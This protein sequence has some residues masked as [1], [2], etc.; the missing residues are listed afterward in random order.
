MQTNK[1]WNKHRK[2]KHQQH[3]YIN[4]LSS[5][6]KININKNNKWNYDM[7]NNTP[8]HHLPIQTQVMQT[9]IMKKNEKEDAKRAFQG[10]TCNVKCHQHRA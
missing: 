10:V 3:I 2:G 1:H 8:E 6:N 5:E 9:Q 4:R 7:K